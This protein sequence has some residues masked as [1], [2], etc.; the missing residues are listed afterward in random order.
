MHMRLAQ[1]KWTLDI[2]MNQ[3]NNLFVLPKY[4]LNCNELWLHIGIAS[5]YKSMFKII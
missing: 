5:I 2:E 1:R 4:S 3:R